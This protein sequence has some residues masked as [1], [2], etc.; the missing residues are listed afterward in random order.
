MSETYLSEAKKCFSYMF[1]LIEL[2]K[3]KRLGG[4][5]ISVQMREFGLNVSPGT[6][7][8]RLGILSKQGVIREE[9]QPWGKNYKTVYQMTEKG[10]E[11]FQR[12]KKNWEK[13]LEY[14]YMN[15]KS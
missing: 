6:I 14:A 4:Y 11:L 12:F 9:R 8:H 10:I 15:L 1:I 3:G 5:D 2:S 7:Y 13:P